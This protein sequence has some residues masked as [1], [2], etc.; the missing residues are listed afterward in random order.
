MTAHQ[1]PGRSPGLPP[2]SDPPRAADLRTGD[3]PCPVCR[4]RRTG[5]RLRGPR[6]YR[7]ARPAIAAGG[8]LTAAARL[9]GRRRCSGRRR[10]RLLGSHPQ[11]QNA[12][13]CA[14]HVGS[15]LDSKAMAGRSSAAL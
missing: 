5:A 2:D 1:L 6:R 14:P 13:S 7:A 4:P 15:C 10:P 9:A 11:H 3:S 8:A 12:E